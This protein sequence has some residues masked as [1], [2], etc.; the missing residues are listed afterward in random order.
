[1]PVSLVSSVLAGRGAQQAKHRV[2]SLL[3]TRA[4]LEA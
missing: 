4:R 2:V 1:M 3:A